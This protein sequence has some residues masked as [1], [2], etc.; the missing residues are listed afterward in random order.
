MSERGNLWYRRIDGLLGPFLVTLLS[1]LR[2]GVEVLPPPRR[3]LFVK[4]GAIGDTLLIDGI[5]RAFLSLHPDVEIHFLTTNTNFEMAERLP[6]V[7]R[8]LLFHLSK[9]IKNPFY[10]ISWLMRARRST[11]DYIFDFE[12]WSYFDAILVALLRGKVKVGFRVS[13]RIK[14]RLFHIPIHHLREVHEIENFKR[15]LELVGLKKWEDPLF[16][17]YRSERERASSILEGAGRPLVVFH[18]GCGGF[19]GYLREWPLENYARLGRDI[20]KR[21]PDATIVF[22]GSS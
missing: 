15:L 18:P 21:F 11:Y 5:A 6:W 17:V 22:T 7:K 16:P 20:L 8:M 9:S 2:K 19:K 10:V 14:D 12:Q 1:F 13:G 4:L 3:V